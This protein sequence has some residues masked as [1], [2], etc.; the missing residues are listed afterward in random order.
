MC[1]VARSC[2]AV[3]DTANAKCVAIARRRSNYR[4][5]ARSAARGS[6]VVLEITPTNDQHDPT[7]S[8]GQS[9]Q[10]P[11]GSHHW[12]GNEGDVVELEKSSPRLYSVSCFVTAN[13]HQGC[14][15]LFCSFLSCIAHYTLPVLTAL[16]PPCFLRSKCDKIT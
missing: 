1:H 2:N 12:E 15:Q 16:C 10:G 3:S 5:T 14:C 9:P 7:D 11:K 4:G 6:R 8:D 13:K